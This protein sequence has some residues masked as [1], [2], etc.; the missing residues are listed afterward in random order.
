M[1]LRHGNKTYFQILLDPHRAQMIQEAAAKADKRATAWIREAVY[2][3][4]KRISQA[5]VYNEA[6]AKDQAEWRQ[7]VRKRVEGRAKPKDD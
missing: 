7:S 5:S 3:E 1:A 4:L 6:V 2:S